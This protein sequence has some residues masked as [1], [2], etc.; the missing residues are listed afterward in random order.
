MT[1]TAIMTAFFDRLNAFVYSPEPI[2]LMPGV[3]TTP[4][5]DGFSLEPLHFPNEPVDRGWEDDSCPEQRGYF[6]IFVCFRPRPKTGLINPSALADAL[7]AHFPKG[8]VL[9]SVRVKKTPW[10]T[11]A[12]TEDASKSYIPITIEYWD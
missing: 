4:P 10:Q 6:R 3:Q 2:I 9:G 8:T 7:I 5:A 11:S 1:T 12:I